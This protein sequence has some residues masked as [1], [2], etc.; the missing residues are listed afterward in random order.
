MNKIFYINISWYKKKKLDIKI[1]KENLLIIYL[2]RLQKQGL[3][4][5][6][7]TVDGRHIGI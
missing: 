4:K 1:D 5:R 3:K 6:R 7:E 2:I